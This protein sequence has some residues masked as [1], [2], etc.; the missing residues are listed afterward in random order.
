MPLVDM[1]V[2]EVNRLLDKERQSGVCQ[3]KMAE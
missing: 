2:S 1:D 3:I